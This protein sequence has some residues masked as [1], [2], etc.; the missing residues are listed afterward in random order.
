VSPSAVD[1]RSHAKL[2]LWISS[3]IVKLETPGDRGAFISFLIEV[4]NRSLTLGNFNGVMEILSSLH[5]AGVSRLKLSWANV[6]PRLMDSLARLDT[7]MSSQGNFANYRKALRTQPPP[8]IPYLGLWL[9]DLTFVDDSNPS[10]LPDSPLLVCIIVTH[11]T[12]P[13]GALSLSLSL[14]ISSLSNSRE[15]A[16]ECF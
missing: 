14:S 15:L 6:S 1:L 10:F 4:A 9:T 2:S 12:R 3:E 16:C 5:S 13:P 11:N 8:F 7:L